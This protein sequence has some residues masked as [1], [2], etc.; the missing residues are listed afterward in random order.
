MK[1]ISLFLIFLLV[2]SG[3]LLAQKA[4]RFKV[5]ALYENGGHHIDYSKAAVNW[6]NK[7]AAAE[8]F[9]IDYIQNTDRI[10][11]AFLSGYQ[12]FIQLDYPP[13]SWK[14]KAVKAFE[15]YIDKGRGGW[16]GFHHA[17]LLG[18]FDGYPLWP[19]FY[20]FMGNIK[21]KNYIAKFA[22]GKVNVEDQ[23]HPVMKGVSPSFWVEKEEWYTYDK[24]PR[25]NVKVLATV[26]EN[27]YE[28]KD[29]ITMGDHPVV[30]TNPAY[31]SR[32]IYIFMGHS[33]ILFDSKDY[34]T[35]FKNAI[36]WTVG[37]P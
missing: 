13:Y 34:T 25:A 20:Q 28:P 9:S 10:D 5:I 12:L 2:N 35:L 18:E 22:R 3:I 30:W 27:T 8:N 26:D 14:D 36:F 16:I 29:G 21:F 6:L 33:P 17:T 37:K 31:K 32:N 4:P 24:S 19:W 1:K 7:L 11:S 15:S 23:K